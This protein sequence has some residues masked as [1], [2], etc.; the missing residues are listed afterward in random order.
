LDPIFK[1]DLPVREAQVIQESLELIRVLVVQS[2]GF[3]RNTEIAIEAALRERLGEVEIIIE[4]VDK[5]PRTSNGK[6]RAVLSNCEPDN[7]KSEP[8]P[9]SRSRGT[10]HQL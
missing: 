1:A 10:Q 8:P 5:I 6:F 9:S 7:F 2:R 3:D 4:K